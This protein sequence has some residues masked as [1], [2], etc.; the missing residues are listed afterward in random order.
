MLSIRDME[1]Y[2]SCS[3]YVPKTGFGVLICNLLIIII[4][5]KEQVFILWLSQG[6][7]SLN[8]SAIMTCLFRKVRFIIFFRLTSY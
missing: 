3:N 8:T 7:V 2:L 5:I 1:V 6:R 4:I